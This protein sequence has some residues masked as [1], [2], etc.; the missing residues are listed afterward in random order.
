[1]FPKNFDT[2]KIYNKTIQKRRSI[3]FNLHPSVQIILLSVEKEIPLPF[4]NSCVSKFHKNVARVAL[5]RIMP[6]KDHFV[7]L[8]SHLCPFIFI[9]LIFFFSWISRK[10]TYP[11]ID[12]FN[13]N[14]FYIFI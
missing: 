9:I 13:I 11:T 6:C 7:Y 10:I 2:I 12:Q 14:S 3:K 4:F 1:M 8:F 5:W